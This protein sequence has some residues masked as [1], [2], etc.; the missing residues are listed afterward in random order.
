MRESVR[1]P[2]IC[3]SSPNL[4]PVS[5]PTTNPTV[6]ARLASARLMRLRLR[7]A[8]GLFALLGA[9]LSGTARADWNALVA[10]ERDGARVTAAAFDLSNNTAV[11]QLNADTRLT[12][13]SLTKLTTAAAALQNWPADKMFQTRLVTVATV[14]DGVLGGDLILRGAGDPSL[15]DKSL[16][17]LAAQLK[18]AGVTSVEG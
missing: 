16:W 6:G 17:S 5:I 10:L 8:A 15:D 12:P 14:H 3:N 2:D 18:G 13:A 11:Q 4:S 1:C 9:L 7:H